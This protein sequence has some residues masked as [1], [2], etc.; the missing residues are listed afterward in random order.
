M[1]LTLQ[2][3]EDGCGEGVGK[4]ILVSWMETESERRA[5]VREEEGWRDGTVLGID[6]TI[7]LLSL[8]ISV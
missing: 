2:V 3:F 1:K 5:R 8:L 4:E 6:C 7:G